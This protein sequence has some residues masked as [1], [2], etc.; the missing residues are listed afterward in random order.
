MLPRTRIL[1]SRVTIGCRS[2]DHTYSKQIFVDQVLI[3]YIILCLFQY[4]H[5][6]IKLNKS[7]AVLSLT[8]LITNSLGK[9]CSNASKCSSE[10]PRLGSI[11]HRVDVTFEESS[12]FSI[13]PMLTMHLGFIRSRKSLVLARNISWLYRYVK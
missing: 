11:H 12:I 1:C 9:I 8:K 13:L 4:L 6:I 2:L 10:D 3:V 5:K 7:I